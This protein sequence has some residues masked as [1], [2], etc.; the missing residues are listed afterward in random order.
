[1]ATGGEDEESKICDE[2]LHIR[3]ST[4]E[5]EECIEFRFGNIFLICVLV[6]KMIHGEV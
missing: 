2:L 6:N 5:N 3:L 4:E 1:M